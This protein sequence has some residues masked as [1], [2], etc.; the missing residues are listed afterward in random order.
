MIGWLA[1]KINNY[2]SNQKWILSKRNIKFYLIFRFFIYNKNIF[3]KWE[4]IISN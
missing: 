3:K 1:I 4:I 2:A